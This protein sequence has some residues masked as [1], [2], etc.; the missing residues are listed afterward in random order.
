MKTPRRQFLR[1]SAVAGR[2][3]VS[4]VWRHRGPGRGALKPIAA[5]ATPK[6]EAPAPT[7]V[8]PEAQ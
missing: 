3:C 4:C 1:I 2:C 7:A 6:A 5:T 8:P